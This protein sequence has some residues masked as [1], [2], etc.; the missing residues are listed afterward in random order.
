LLVADSHDPRQIHLLA[1]LPA[2]VRTRLFPHL[3]LVPLLWGTQYASPVCRCITSFSPT[4]A[5]VS[6][7]YVL[8]DGASAEIAVVGN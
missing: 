2:G 4:T 1:A 3:E 6:L 5:I 7:L 8:D